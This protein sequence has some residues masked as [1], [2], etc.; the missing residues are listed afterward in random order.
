[1]IYKNLEIYDV[2]DHKDY[3]AL[4]NK[5]D[6]IRL[7][8]KAQNNFHVKIR[9]DNSSGYKGVFKNYKGWGSKISVNK[10]IIYLGTFRTKEEAHVA[11]CAA[12]K[13]YHGEFGRTA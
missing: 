8:T 11:Y 1:M 10:E 3:D 4:N 7:A 6:N 2:I 12:S 5:I 9:K 13:K